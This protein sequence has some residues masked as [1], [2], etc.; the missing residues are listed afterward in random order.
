MI[1]EDFSQYKKYQ[2]AT[3]YLIK[4]KINL[5]ANEEVSIDNLK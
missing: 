1:V 4:Q 3:N 5:N 2:I